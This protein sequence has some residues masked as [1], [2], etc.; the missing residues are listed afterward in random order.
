MKQ[1]QESLQQH[2]DFFFDMKRTVAIQ[3]IKGSFHDE[4]AQHYF[5]NQIEILACDSFDLLVQSVVN[6]QCYQ[7]SHGLR[8][9]DCWL[10]F[11]QLRLA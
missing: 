8:K 3:G 10:D 2:Q 5:G 7:S 11:A 9:L 1:I 4:V 6:D